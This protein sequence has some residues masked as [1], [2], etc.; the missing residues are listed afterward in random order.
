MGPDPTR[1]IQD[2]IGE[3]PTVLKDIFFVFL[4]TMDY[5]SHV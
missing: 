2:K 5:S 4:A 1:R 3:A